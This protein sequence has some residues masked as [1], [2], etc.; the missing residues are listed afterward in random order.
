MEIVM[1]IVTLIFVAYTVVTITRVKQHVCQPCATCGCTAQHLEN[2]VVSSQTLAAMGAVAPPRSA[3]SAMAQEPDTTVSARH[4]PADTR[5]C[6]G[7]AGRSEGSLQASGEIII[8][9]EEDLFGL[10]SD[11]EQHQPDTVP[12]ED[13][14]LDED[15]GLGAFGVPMTW[16][17]V[18]AGFA[19]TS[20]TRPSEHASQKHTSEHRVSLSEDIATLE[21]EL[22]TLETEQEHI[23][24]CPTDVSTRPPGMAADA[25]Q[26]PE[27]DI[28]LGARGMGMARHLKKAGFTVRT[29]VPHA[30]LAPEEREELARQE[31][32]T[33]IP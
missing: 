6:F 8:D 20:L 32:R 22:E 31:S 29:V 16:P 27:E 3:P 5:A 19:I 18:Q 2:R 21:M 28:V 17:L 24:P 10:L 33:N 26:G 12:D 15:I 13:V 25:S 4:T 23:T 7:S 14:L 11:E 1:D 30:L 9:T